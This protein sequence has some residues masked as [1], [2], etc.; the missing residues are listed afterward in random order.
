MFGLLF[1]N[2]MYSLQSEDIQQTSNILVCGPALL[3]TIV[4]T[5]KDESP[6]NTELYPEGFIY[7]T[8]QV[9]RTVN[10]HIYGLLCCGFQL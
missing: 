1:E 10:P 3:A 2:I 8:F 4:I 5:F 7:Y 6:E 9:P